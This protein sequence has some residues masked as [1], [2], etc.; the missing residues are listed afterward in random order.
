M[1]VTDAA[2]LEGIF[3]ASDAAPVIL[4]QHDPYCP[5]STRAYWQL[6]RLSAPVPLVDVDAAPHLARLIAERTGV[7][8]E[9]PQVLVLEHGRATWSASHGAITAEAVQHASSVEVDTAPGA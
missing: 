3:A 8:H 5:I 9:S 2:A 6:A 4:F 7:R 1:P